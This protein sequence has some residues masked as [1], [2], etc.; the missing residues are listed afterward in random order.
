MSP[1]E[2]SST[3]ITL[4]RDLQLTQLLQRL[5]L[6]EAQRLGLPKLKVDV[7]LNVD[8]PDD[9]EDAL[10]E[11][12]DGPDPASCDWIPRRMNVFQVKATDMPPRKCA[13]ELERGGSLRPRVRDVLDRSGSY[14]LFYGR[15]CAG[16]AARKRVES[17]REELL[18]HANGD[19]VDSVEVQ[20]LGAEKI[21]EWTNGHAPAV[22]LVR[23]QLG[24]GVPAFL[25]PWRE[26]SQEWDN[27]H[28]VRMPFYL[29]S[30]EPQMHGLREHLLEPSRVARLVGLPGFGKTRLALE[31]FSPGAAALG[32]IQQEVLSA[33]CVYI[34]DGE[35]RESEVIDTVRLLGR[36]G[37]SGVIVVDECPVALH[38]KLAA[39]VEAPGSALSL[40]TLDFDPGL[41]PDSSTCK[42]VV[43][44]PLDRDDMQALLQLAYPQIGEG[45]KQVAEL[46]QGNPRMA[47]LMVRASRVGGPPLWESSNLDLAKRIV[48]R[49]SRFGERLFD[50]AMALSIF[51]RLG[52]TDTA[53]YELQELARKLLGGANVSDV[54]GMIADLQE[55]GVLYRRGDYVR[56]TPIPLAIIL[57]AEWWKGCHPNLAQA[58]L[59]GAVLPISMVQSL[60]SQL[61]F[62]KGHRAAEGLAGH[63]LGPASPFATRAQLS[64]AA[65]A[66]IVSALAE[67]SP[68]IVCRALESAF[69]GATLAELLEVQEGRRDLVQA[70]EKLAWWPETFEGA[71]SLLLL[72]GAAENEP[73]GNN[74]ASQFKQLY[75]LALSGTEVPARERLGVIDRGL[76]HSEVSMRRLALEA[77][78]EG[79]ET[80]HFSRMGGAESQAGR[81]PREDWSPTDSRD[82]V[83]YW[84]AILER[85]TPMLGEA[86]KEG[87]LARTQI[88]TRARG[89]VR[90]GGFPIVERASCAVLAA[91]KAWPEMADSLRTTISYD[92]GRLG[93]AVVSRLT[94]LAG[95]L[96]PI[97]LGT[98]LGQVV[99][100]SD[101]RGFHESADGNLTAE[102]ELRATQL[103]EELAHD[104]P[105]LLPYL[106]SL[107][108]GEQREGYA[109]GRALGLH[110]DDA[111]LIVLPALEAFRRIPSERRNA[112]LLMGMLSSAAR[113]DK[114]SAR[115]L[116]HPLLYDVELG[117][118][119]AELIRA[120][121]P[122]DVD[123][124][125]VTEALERKAL[126]AEAVNGYSI[127]RA[128]QPIDKQLVARFL[129]AVHGCQGDGLGVALDLLGM[130]VEGGALHDELTGVGR[131]LLLDRAIPTK[132][133][134]AR[135]MLDYEFKLVAQAVLCAKSTPPV[136]VRG[137]TWI[138]LRMSRGLNLSP[139]V[140]EVL[141]GLVEQHGD[142]AWPVIKEAFSEA[143][144]KYAGRLAMALSREWRGSIDI[145]SAVGWDRLREWCETEPNARQW[146][147]MLVPTIEQNSGD[148]GQVG[149]SQEARELIDCYGDHELVLRSLAANALSGGWSGSAV[150]LLSAQRAAF[151]ML[152]PHGNPGV[153][154]WARSRVA[155]LD[156]QIVSEQKRDQEREFGHY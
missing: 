5:L 103:G 112:T 51:D 64:S 101:L 25:Q 105:L 40:L 140:R 146:V 55:G 31:L 150:P 6:L 50:F 18:K 92:S 110:A 143:N 12:H 111:L 154:K 74:A 54:W 19:Q 147:A 122:D 100:A 114:E 1:F 126:R 128:L 152:M 30:R 149:W 119:A 104:V 17:M 8:V 11:W 99:G 36:Q 139:E 156:T 52:V 151:A 132:L 94:E 26:W 29:G 90:A 87:D 76:G 7:S 85:L 33:R 24:R 109:F 75:H 136:F 45:A 62:L 131:E 124:L 44:G 4:L 120:T 21:A 80:S 65:G 93:E 32:E 3:D 22:A 72:L 145:V 115:Q 63:I 106:S 96:D 39:I 57:A 123:I 118:I 66:R 84:E 127:G 42:S 144:W 133:K 15:C 107:L 35:S 49:R 141:V 95:R 41:R 86:G 138:I 81:L 58:M 116:L 153:S 73:W 134:L 70:L 43:L 121:V 2:V 37:A 129:R 53:G 27:A 82:A 14:T 91:G 89:L 60:T 46:A 125:A 34:G 108:M 79:L 78:G 38:N 130:Q 28:E 155:A 97:D 59:S 98:R 117:G 47:E 137:F 113:R 23:E 142:L 10:I 148:G 48:I 61:R 77:L 9:G 135:P 71:A 69:A 102:S 83:A 68:G 56:L 16:K 67:A 20:V 13:Q 88:S